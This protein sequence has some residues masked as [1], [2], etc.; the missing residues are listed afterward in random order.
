MGDGIEFLGARDT[1][2]TLGVEITTKTPRHQEKAGMSGGSLNLAIDWDFKIESRL[3]LRA[4][5]S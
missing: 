3:I 5:M 2:G 4:Q 1:S